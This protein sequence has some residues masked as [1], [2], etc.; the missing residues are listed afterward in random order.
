M[1]R[2]PDHRVQRFGTAREC[3]AQMSQE[4]PDVITLDY[5][6]PDADGEHTLRQLRKRPLWSFRGRRT[7]SPPWPCCAWGPTTTS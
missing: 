6:L 4:M 3:L 5:S 1:G 2:N 7:W